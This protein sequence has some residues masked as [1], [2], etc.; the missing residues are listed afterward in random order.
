MT[1]QDLQVRVIYLSGQLEEAK[2]TLEKALKEKG[3]A[4]AAAKKDDGITAGQ[5]QSN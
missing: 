3:E 2:L 1:L 5:Q 4:D